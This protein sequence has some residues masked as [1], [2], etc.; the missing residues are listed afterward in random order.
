MGTAQAGQ[1]QARPGARRAP[2]AGQCH[3]GQRRH[4]GAYISAGSQG[5]SVRALAAQRR[6]VPAPAPAAQTATEVGESMHAQDSRVGLS[7]PVHC[8]LNARRKA[9]WGDEH[10]K[11]TEGTNDQPDSDSE[12]CACHASRA[13]NSTWAQEC[14]AARRGAA[15][16]K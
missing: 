3:L 14:G 12:G 9:G 5:I 1:C 10:T 13:T 7:L 15:E 6:C 16:E 2:P 4:A 11:R 8:A